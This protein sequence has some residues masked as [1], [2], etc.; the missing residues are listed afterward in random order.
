[1]APVASGRRDTLTDW[2]RSMQGAFKVYVL[3]GVIV[4]AVVY[5]WTDRMARDDGAAFD[6]SIE[7]ARH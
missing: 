1:L 6:R 4:L 3:L 5:F 7:A 2:R